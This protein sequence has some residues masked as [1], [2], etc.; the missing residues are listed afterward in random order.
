MPDLDDLATLRMIHSYLAGLVPLL[1]TT[2]KA[3]SDER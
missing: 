2:A 3:R 1:A